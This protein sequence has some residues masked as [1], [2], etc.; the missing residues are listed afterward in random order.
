MKLSRIAI[1]AVAGMTFLTTQQAEAQLRRYA[2]QIGRIVNQVQRGQDRHD[3]HGSP[4]HND[5]HQHNNHQGHAQHYPPANQHIIHQPHH[6]SHT[7]QVIR[8]G[9]GYHVDHHDH[10]VRDSHGHIIGRYH[11]DVIHKDASYVVPHVGIHMDSYY[12]QNGQYFYT[13][14]TASRT[15][16]VNRPIAVPYGSFS[17]VD[18]LASR[19]EELTNEFLLDL[20]YNYQHNPGFAQ[21]YAEGYELLQVAKYI[22]AAEHAQDRNAIR[23]RLG[24]MDALFHHLEGDVRGWSRRHHRQIGQLGILSKM[25]MI[26]STLHHLM[27]DVG[28]GQAPAAIGPE[29]APPPAGFA[30]APLMVAPLPGR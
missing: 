8:Q 6:D 3:D 5:N 11:H 18:D 12:V 27:H 25:E 20:H 16:V 15:Q 13:P 10:V 21:T 29:V 24:G 2:N 22:H 7:S 9:N 4:R 19:L 17:H 28:V 14:Q 23:S 26:E 30:P 1:I